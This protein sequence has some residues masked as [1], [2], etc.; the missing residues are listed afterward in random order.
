MREKG[1]D[2]MGVRITQLIA[3]T[4]NKTIHKHR[5]ARYKHER[6]TQMWQ[7]IERARTSRRACM[8]AVLS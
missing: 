5:T 6:A 7:T 4:A 1:R 3:K 8:N 2:M